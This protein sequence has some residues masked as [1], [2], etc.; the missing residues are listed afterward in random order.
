MTWAEFEADAWK[1]SH[2]A[3]SEAFFAIKP[4]PE[5]AS[6]EVLLS[7]LYRHIGF[8]KSMGESKVP[9][10]GRLLEKS[11]RRL[12]PSDARDEIWRA[13]LS[14]V[15]E[16]PKLPNQASKP[17]L[18]LTPIVPEVALYSGSARRAGNSWPAGRLIEALVGFGSADPV[19]AWDALFK[20]LSVDDTDD[21]WARWVQAEFLARRIHTEHE[22]QRSHLENTTKISFGEIACPAHQFARDLDAILAA[23]TSMTRAQWTSL[24][25]AIFRLGG[26]AHILWLCDVHDRVWRCL[27]RC[28]NDGVCP[29]PDEFKEE[30]FPEDLTYL[31]YGKAAVP[32][33]RDYANRYLTARIGI[34]AVLWHLEGETEPMES[35]GA[36]YAVCE[37]TAQQHRSLAKKG[38][39]NKFAG[40][41]EREARTLSCKKG[42][43]SNMVEFGRHVL[44]Q[45]QSASDVLRGYDQAYFLRKK[46]TYATAPWVVSFGPAAVISLVHCCMFKSSGPRSVHRLA[47]HLAAYGVQVDAEELL[48]GELASKLRLLGLVL[49]SPDAETGMLL[50]APFKIQGTGGGA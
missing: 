13:V 12:D 48:S 9:V 7:G 42:I 29:P 21:V 37:R 39:M 43:G 33:V 32:V 27:R 3:Y 41:Q 20:H 22:W 16:S 28:L 14:R 26:A 50:L 4:A 49:D 40:L 24:L 30:V 38:V 47:Q 18:Q 6:G 15:L 17:F 11:L 10:E 36:L 44:G 8:K 35:P 46:G 45:R 1:K 5:Y 25:G 19:A 2:K 23:K 31:D 34:N